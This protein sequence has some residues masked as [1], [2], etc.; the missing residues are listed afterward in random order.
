MV[1]LEFR[2]ILFAVQ[3]CLVNDPCQNGASCFEMD[4]VNVDCMCNFGYEGDFCE[5]GRLYRI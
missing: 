4:G 2:K 1:Q 3:V 5:T